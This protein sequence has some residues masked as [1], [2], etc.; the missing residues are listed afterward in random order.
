MSSGARPEERRAFCAQPSAPSERRAKGR[1][2]QQDD[3]PPEQAP[4]QGAASDATVLTAVFDAAADAI[5]V[6]DAQGNTTRANAAALAMFGYT[7]DELIG[8]NVSMLMPRA[9]ADLHD[10]FMHHHL[11]TGE[12]RIIGSGREVEG[13]RKNG[14]AFPLHLSVGRATVDDQPVFVAILHD[15][16]RRAAAEEAL[17]RSQRLDAIGQMTGGVAHDFNNLLT[18]II[19]SLEL[20]R[21]RLKDEGAR[22]LARDALEAAELGADLT[23]RLLVFASNS[24]LRPRQ[25]DLNRI[26]AASLSILT[27]ALGSMIRIETRFDDTIALV[28]VDPMQLQTSIMNIVLNARDAMPSGGV[29]RFETQ[30]I[31]ID[32]DY[33]S[34]ETNVAMGRYVRL[35]IGDTG[36]GMPLEARRRAFEP[37]FTTKAVGKGTGLGLSMVYG[38][39]KQSGGYITL[40]SEPD[41]GTSFGLYFPALSGSVGHRTGAAAALAADLPRGAGERVLVVEDN[42]QL[43]RLTRQRLLDLGY[44]PQQAETADAALVA[45]RT[46]GGQFDLL[47]SDLV[48]P[49]SMNGYELA[50]RV[51]AHY[52]HIKILLTSGY[53]E[54]IMRQHASGRDVPLSHFDVIRKPYSQSDLAHKLQ[55]LFSPE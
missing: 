22:D 20:L 40:Y 34:Q 25:V 44:V 18:V 53:S 42:A 21:M 8:R 7:E 47:F 31:D 43:R 16:S 36:H 26:C 10:A 12:R 11:T 38:F 39:V 41:Q 9:L 3:R 48:M 33:I 4:P 37:F 35:T 24:E 29:L 46:Q 5:L 54:D 55:A 32:D 17:S 23:S 28:S 13:W 52:P 30:V 45:L 27:R 14:T 1:A 51:R 19:G 2:A 50:L 15:L 49:G 6:S